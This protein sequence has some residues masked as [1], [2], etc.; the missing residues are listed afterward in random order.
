VCPFSTLKTVLAV[1]RLAAPDEQAAS[2][3][4]DEELRSS[5]LRH[6]Q[7]THQP[8]CGSDDSAHEHPCR[9]IGG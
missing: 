5:S 9:L 7:Q 4:T 3:G 2:S 8:D 6:L 1:A